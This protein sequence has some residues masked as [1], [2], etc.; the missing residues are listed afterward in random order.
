MTNTDACHGLTVLRFF[1]SKSLVVVDTVR[2]PSFVNRLWSHHMT[3]MEAAD[4]IVIGAGISGL[5]AADQLSRRGH[6]VIV[7][8]ATNRVGGRT[9]TVQLEDGMYADLGAMWLGP[10][11]ANMLHLAKELGITLF[12]QFDEGK[13]FLDNGTKI[14]H[15]QGTIPTLPLLTLIEVQVSLV[16][17][18]EAMVK[19]VPVDAPHSCPNA[20]AWD[21]I[22]VEGWKQATL[23]TRE[24]K[25]M[26]DL[27]VR[28]VLGTEATD[29][30]LLFF[31]WYA[32]A[33]GG[34]MPLLEME[35][36]AQ[37]QRASGGMQ[38]I[39]EKLCARIS[40]SG[41]GR[42]VF[43]AAV[44][45]VQDR[46]AMFS[47]NSSQLASTSSNDVHT[48]WSC[49]VH[50]TDGRIFFS[51]YV[52]CAIPPKL[53]STHISFQPA[54]PADRTRV[55]DRMFMGNYTKVVVFYER[56]FWRARGLSGNGIRSRP[57]EENLVVG[58]FDYCR[59][60]GECPGLACFCTGD[61][62]IKLDDLSEADRHNHVVRLVE[63]CA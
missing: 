48:D 57:S 34:I 35:G 63:A 19:S 10:T 8:E 24:A 33:A 58:V 37:E 52:V 43:S 28:L 45:S 30:S 32:N 9:E 51:S 12:P 31:L 47:N 39:S 41:R 26:L 13:S 54:L 7:L 21:S 2:Q 55:V 23:Y 27:T 61:M 1:E 42:C 36:G 16:W 6:S 15:Y 18:L 59:P 46:E 14:G 50:T 4:V 40:K 49:V 44:S 3:P 38:Q 56:A 5:Y 20:A 53:T 11:Q 60:G 25:E 62:A 22:S 29:V 17:R